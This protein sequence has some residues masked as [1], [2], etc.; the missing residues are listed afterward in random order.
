MD[1]GKL[2]TNVINTFIELREILTFLKIN[3]NLDKGML[4][5]I[6]SNA[7][8]IEMKFSNIVRRQCKENF[9]KSRWKHQECLFQKIQNSNK[10]SEKRENK[11]WKKLCYS[12]TKKSPESLPLLVKRHKKTSLLYKLQE[13]NNLHKHDISCL[14]SDSNQ[15]ELIPD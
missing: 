13:F 10:T 7:P 2:L 12:K 11:M 6:N 3:S 8:E 9:T 15:E 1:R 14:R 4:L 5:E